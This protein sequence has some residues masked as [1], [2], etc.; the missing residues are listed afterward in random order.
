MQWRRSILLIPVV[1]APMPWSSMWMNTKNYHN[2][3][4]WIVFT[5]EIDVCIYIHIIQHNVFQIPF[6][7]WHHP[8]L[9]SNPA[10]RGILA[11]RFWKLVNGYQIMT[12]NNLTI[13][14]VPILNIVISCW[15]SVLNCLVCHWMLNSGMIVTLGQ[16]KLSSLIFRVPR[17]STNPKLIPFNY[18]TRLW[19]SKHIYITSFWWILITYIYFNYR[20]VMK[21]AKANTIYK[22]KAHRPHRSPEST[23]PSNCSAVYSFFLSIFIEFPMKKFDPIL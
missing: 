6:D 22:Q 9:V 8:A 5:I 18:K 14:P 11:C 21:T 7:L 3:P 13:S 12:F 17:S 16:C 23:W 20:K 10:F 19:Q 1:M 4:S 15:Q 2:A